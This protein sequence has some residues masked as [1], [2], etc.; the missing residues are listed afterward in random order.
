MCTTVHMTFL[1]HNNDAMFWYIIKILKVSS[2]NVILDQKL[3]FIRDC[4]LRITLNKKVM[5]FRVLD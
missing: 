3:N 5:Q 4:V 1:S 2:L